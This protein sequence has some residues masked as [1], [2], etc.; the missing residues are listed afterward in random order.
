MF[1]DPLPLLVLVDIKGTIY[2]FSTKYHLKNPYKLLTQWKNMYSIQ[3][4]S[5]ITFVSSHYEQNKDTEMITCELILGDEF[6]YIRIVD[7]S[8]FIHDK[9]IKPV[10]P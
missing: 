1:I 6:G 3:K 9:E 5:Q 7:I 8:G 2:L 10:T 4:S